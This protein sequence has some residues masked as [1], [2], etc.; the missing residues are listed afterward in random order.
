MQIDFILSMAILLVA[1]FFIHGSP[2]GYVTAMRVRCIIGIG[3]SII[4]IFIA[5]IFRLIKGV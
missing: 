3:V 2:G 1:M 4:V 5:L